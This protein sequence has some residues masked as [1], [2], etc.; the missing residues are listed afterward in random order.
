[1]R[2]RANNKT[3][4]VNNWNAC[5]VVF[6]ETR[7]RK[8]A[9]DTYLVKR[10]DDYAIRLHDTDIVTFHAPL[11]PSEARASMVTL[12][13]GGQRTVTSKARMNAFGDGRWLVFKSK[14]V[15]YVDIPHRGTLIY[16]DGMHIW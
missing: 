7:K 14:K 3:Y 10:G 13:T 16:R 11:L 5:H 1:M 9:N 2:I 12:D 15:W 8:L 4:S 6:T